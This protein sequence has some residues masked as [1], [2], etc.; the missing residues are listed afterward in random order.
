VKD[1]VSVK[2]SR[3]GGFPAGGALDRERPFDDAGALVPAN[4]ATSVRR[5]IRSADTVSTPEQAAVPSARSAFALVSI[6]ISRSG[7]V[8]G[9]GTDRSTGR[10]YGQHT[11]G[12]ADRRP[13]L[14]HEQCL[15]SSEPLV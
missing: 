1:R 14:A 11:G 9:G 7:C 4:V 6:A 5:S 10:A 3:F 2:G 15:R 8:A 12:D 13:H